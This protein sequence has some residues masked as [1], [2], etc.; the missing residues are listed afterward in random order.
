M[1]PKLRAKWEQSLLK[2][3]QRVDDMREY[4]KNREGRL[5]F[6]YTNMNKNYEE[7][8]R[9]LRAFDSVKT[10][11]S[12]F[13]DVEEFLQNTTNHQTTPQPPPKTPHQ[14][15]SQQPPRLLTCCKVIPHSDDD[16][17]ERYAIEPIDEPITDADEWLMNL[18][19][20]ESGYPKRPNFY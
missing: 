8:Y 2:A 9:R 19:I 15:Q 18:T 11:C 17:D 10:Y 3:K 5:S 14:P 4:I 16:D 20:D 6:P 12:K 13:F 1:N 7:Y